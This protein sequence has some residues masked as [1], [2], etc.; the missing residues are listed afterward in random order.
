MSMVVHRWFTFTLH[1]TDHS[2][3]MQTVFV[4]GKM[5]LLLHDEKGFK[6]SHSAE[7]I[8]ISHQFQSEVLEQADRATTWILQKAG[9]GQDQ[10]RTGEYTTQHFNLFCTSFG[11]KILW[12]STIHN[13]D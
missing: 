3:L 11:G 8:I 12:L 7:A 10:T 5:N 1:Y 4:Q 13:S 2:I 6:G 9:K